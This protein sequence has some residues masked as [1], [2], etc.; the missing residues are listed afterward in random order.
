ML[1]AA[2]KLSTD[3]IDSTDGTDCIDC[4][5]C[6]DCTDGKEPEAPSLRGFD[7]TRRVKR[8]PLPTCSQSVESV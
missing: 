6:T 8:P 1:K 7:I 5:D 2:V 4:I 3:C